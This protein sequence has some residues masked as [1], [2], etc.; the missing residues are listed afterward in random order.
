MNEVKEQKVKVQQMN[1]QSELPNYIP[2][3]DLQQLPESTLPF[4]SDEI[5]A[6]LEYIKEMDEIYRSNGLRVK[7]CT[8]NID[9][10]SQIKKYDNYKL[11]LQFTNSYPLVRTKTLN[12]VP[13]AC[14]R[15]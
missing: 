12:F 11:F 8:I 1:M 4:C 5:K 2:A 10:Q 14:S 15:I 6:H 13:L 7:H 3:G 9:D